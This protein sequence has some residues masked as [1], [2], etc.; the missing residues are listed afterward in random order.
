[1]KNGHLST[2]T[3]DTQNKSR[4]SPPFF[5]CSIRINFFFAE[6]SLLTNPRNDRVTIPSFLFPLK[7]LGNTPLP[8]LNIPLPHMSLI[9]WPR[10]PSP[11]YGIFPCRQEPHSNSCL[12]TTPRKSYAPIVGKNITYQIQLIVPGGQITTSDVLDYPG[13]R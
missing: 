12:A 6:A 10:S 13:R 2:G 7:E 4:L 1:M 3:S 8:N 9:E 11:R 5:S